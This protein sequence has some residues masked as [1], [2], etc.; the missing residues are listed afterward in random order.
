V[1]LARTLYLP[2]VV[3][4]VPPFPSVIPAHAGIQ[5]FY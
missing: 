4:V 5:S 1:P 3:S 2:F